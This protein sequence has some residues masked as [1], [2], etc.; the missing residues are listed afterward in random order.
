M[1][2]EDATPAAWVSSVAEPLS[3]GRFEGREAFE[4]LIRAALARAAQ[5]GWREIVLS[6]ATFADWPLCERVVADSLQAWSA[7]G[8]RFIM[9]ATGFDEVIR[10]H[11]RFVS[12]RK[13][14]GHI[15]DCRL[16]KGA[17]A[18]D[19]PSAIWTQGWFMHRLDTQRSHG[20]C[21]VDRMRGIQLKELLD[22]KIRNSS[23]GFPSSTLGL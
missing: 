20:V 17:H 15:I 11:A 12:W 14:W 23:V 10:R 21:G 8:R 9:L 6:D 22:E 19:F 4:Q 2:S 16:C 3:T 7:S 13:T 1:D 18:V 5:E